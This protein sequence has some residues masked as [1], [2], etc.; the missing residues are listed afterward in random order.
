MSEIASTYA[1]S[2][3]EILLNVHALTNM[4]RASGDD[5]YRKAAAMWIPNLESTMRS[6]IRELT[7]EP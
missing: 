3:M 2:L 6:L 4:H 7:K 5:E 1:R